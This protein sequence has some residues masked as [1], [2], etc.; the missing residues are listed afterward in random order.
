MQN[1]RYGGVLLLAA[2]SGCGQGREVD[3]HMSDIEA[4]L[5]AL[6]KRVATADKPDK[7]REPTPP[8]NV[9]I[10]PPHDWWCM[11]PSE[12][13]QECFFTKD[14]CDDLR[15]FINRVASKTG[16]C[17]RQDTAWCVEQSGRDGRWSRMCAI[18]REQ[19]EKYVTGNAH[20]SANNSLRQFSES[21]C[22]ER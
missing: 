16:P 22:E 18:N 17:T 12:G 6:E 8:P 21:P 3:Q 11:R 1:L 2:T 4:R 9:P 20:L 19:C 5:T 7:E 15:T 10:R 13:T 14:K